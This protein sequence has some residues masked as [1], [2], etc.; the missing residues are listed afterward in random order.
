MRAALTNFERL[1]AVREFTRGCSPTRT[2]FETGPPPR[3]TCEQ[4]GRL[5]ESVTLNSRRKE[6][7]VALHPYLSDRPSFHSLVEAQLILLWDR[8]DA[9]REVAANERRAWLE[10]IGGD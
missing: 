9:R 7:L 6:V 10:S 3:L 8:E 1:E 5:A 4:L 2:I